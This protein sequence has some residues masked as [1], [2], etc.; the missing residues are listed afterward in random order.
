MTKMRQYRAELAG[1]AALSSMAYSEAI[2]LILDGFLCSL[3]ILG[4]SLEANA[5]VLIHELTQFAS[6]DICL[7]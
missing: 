4:V 2:L 1:L 6:Q 5:L 3:S 7:L